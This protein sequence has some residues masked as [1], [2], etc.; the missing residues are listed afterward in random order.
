MDELYH[1]GVKGM[2]WGVRRRLRAAEA[3]ERDAKDL[4]KHGFTKEADAVSK[5]ASKNRAR[6]AEIERK[7]S[8]RKK[9]KA[10]K[11]A[12]KA[13]YKRVKQNMKRVMK[14][15]T[16]AAVNTNTG[17]LGAINKRTGETDIFHIGKEDARRVEEYI[18]RYNKVSAA[19]IIGSSA[20]A[21]A[22]LAY[23]QYKEF[24]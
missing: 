8:E 1:Y 17:M 24:L 18:E 2:K 20:A 13:E 10:Q 6:A 15:S 16:A 19:A 21:M 5:V 9:Q 7:S 22:G 14:N 12:E 3:S 23:L 4:R 11:K